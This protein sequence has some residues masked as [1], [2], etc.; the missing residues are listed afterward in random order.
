MKR[1]FLITADY[2]EKK[3]SQKRQGR[4]KALGTSKN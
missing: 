3:K 2:E 4:T 1:F